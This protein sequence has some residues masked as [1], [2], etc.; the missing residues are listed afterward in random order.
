MGHGPGLGRGTHVR[1]SPPG[2]DP[3]HSGAKGTRRRRRRPS[4]QLFCMDRL[5]SLSARRLFRFLFLPSL[6]GVHPLPASLSSGAPPPGIFPC[7]GAPFLPPGTPM[8][9]VPAERPAADQGREKTT[10]LHRPVDLLNK[11]PRPRRRSS[12]DSPQPPPLDLASLPSSPVPLPFPASGPSSPSPAPKPTATEQLV[13][14]PTAIS[15]N[16]NGIR[17]KIGI[18]EA[19][20]AELRPLLFIVQE[21][22][23]GPKA[24]FK[25]PSGYSIHRR[26]RNECG[27]GV[28]VLVRDELDGVPVSWSPLPAAPP[29]LEAVGVS[30]SC[31]LFASNISA[32]SIYRPPGLTAARAAG[33]LHDLGDFLADIASLSPAL[34]IA[35][36]LNCELSAPSGSPEGQVRSILEG[37]GLHSV[38]PTSPT[39]GARTIDWVYA[40]GRVVADS[41]TGLPPMEKGAFGHL[42]LLIPLSTRVAARPR[43]RW[44]EVPRWSRMDAAAAVAS[45][46]GPVPLLE[47]VAHLPSATEV[48]G[49]LEVELR[50]AIAASVPMVRFRERPGTPRP[51]WLTL[52]CRLASVRCQEAWEQLKRLRSRPCPPAVLNSAVARYKTAF[53]RRRGTIA[54]AKRSFALRTIEDCRAGRSLWDL[55]RR[56]SGKAGSDRLSL[57]SSDGEKTSDPDKVAGLLAAQFSSVTTG[58]LPSLAASHP[59]P[60]FLAPDAPPMDVPEEALISSEGAASLLAS[61]NPRKATGLDQI[62]SSFLRATSAVLGPAYAHLLNLAIRRQETPSQWRSAW[63][64]PIAKKPGA[65]SADQFRAISILPSLSKGFE[66]FALSLLE[67][68]PVRLSHCRQFGFAPRSSCSDAHLHL[69]QKVIKLASVWP[70]GKPFRLL[71]CSFDAAKAFDVAPHYSI[72]RALLDDGCPGWLSRL[73]QSWLKGRTQVVR[74]QDGSGSYATSAPFP[75]LSGTPQGATSSPAL[76]GVLVRPSL[77]LPFTPGSAMQLYADDA[78]LIRPWITDEDF[79]HFQRDTNLLSSWMSA[80]GLRFNPAK[81]RL[82]ILSLSARPVA[83]PRPLVVNGSEVPVVESFRYL[84]VDLDRRLSLSE[85]WLGVASSAKRSLGALG[86]LVEWQWQAGGLVHLIRERVLPFLLF[87]LTPCPPSSSK[88]WGL[89]RSL[90]TYA[91]RRSLNNF[92]LE[93]SELME[94]AGLPSAASLASVA[95]LWLM[96]SAVIGG[97]RLGDSL[98]LG[99]HPRL[100]QPSRPGL[101]SR[102][103]PVDPATATFLVQPPPPTRFSSLSRLGLYSLVAT[104]NSF[105]LSQGTSAHRVISCRAS[106]AK[107]AEL[108]SLNLPSD[109][110]GFYK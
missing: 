56:L 72:L 107:S 14:R 6:S 104:W 8:A 10:L 22:K 38:G 90:L 25:P 35:G 101:R 76:Y 12:Q 37:F 18:L 68:S 105:V 15:V 51:P 85:H 29:P 45:L 9:S 52:E 92:S 54:S 86:R 102:H 55:H 79:D 53:R 40:S 74:V 47:R 60:D 21:T 98:T 28:A 41:V 63:V 100:S 2:L 20:A 110:A 44:V 30:L 82:M 48:C 27:G 34:L 69:Q 42:S 81:S 75:V 23:L 103:P 78:L 32:V 26:D 17:S 84:G 109:I 94:R 33:F 96:R 5:I 19:V 24:D 39:H 64:A 91:A 71:A 49:Q 66:R 58:Q 36:D 97:R 59:L 73:F 7:S 108:F 43:P 4:L 46:A 70:Q 62:P 65:D 77:D 89:I 50:A 31:R 13:G 3:S 106:F 99:D 16:L 95:G 1:P 80:R 93:G 88:S 11:A 67:S 57:R 83:P 61:L 87:S